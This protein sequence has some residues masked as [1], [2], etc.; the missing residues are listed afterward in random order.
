MFLPSGLTRLPPRELPPAPEWTEF[1]HPIHKGKGA[2]RQDCLPGRPDREAGNSDTDFCLPQEDTHRQIPRLQLPPPCQGA[3]RSC[4]VFEGQSWE[5][6]WR[7]K[8]MEWDPTPQTSVQSQRLSRT[9]SE[10]QPERKTDTIQHHHGEWDA[11]PPPPSSFTF[12]MIKEWVNKL[13]RCANDW[14]WK[15]WWR[16]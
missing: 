8:V 6:M 2:G 5:G 12:L 15:Q 1:L 14:W 3:A 7:R 4:A 11:P 9:C 13:R 10:K 16:L